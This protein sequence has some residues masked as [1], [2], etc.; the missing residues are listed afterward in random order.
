MG[1]SESSMRFLDSASTDVAGTDISANADTGVA[2]SNTSCVM[3]SNYELKQWLLIGMSALHL[4][5]YVG[6][7]TV[8]KINKLR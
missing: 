4:A 5:T 1:G 7:S 8:S 6:K 3:D 2:V